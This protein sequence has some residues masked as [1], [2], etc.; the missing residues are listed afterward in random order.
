[1]REEQEGAMMG[2]MEHFWWSGFGP[3]FHFS[4]LWP[5][6]FVLWFSFGHRARAHGRARQ[7]AMRHHDPPAALPP[8]AP[9]PALDALRERFARGEIDRAEYEERRAILL[10][11]PPI[12]TPKGTTLPAPTGQESRP[13]WPD[14]S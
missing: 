13:E 5:L 9:D 10:S 14:L 3:G 11:R 12:A 1:V 6:F 8:A 4:W 2:G 7:R